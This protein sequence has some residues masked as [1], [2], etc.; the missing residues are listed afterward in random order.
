MAYISF[1]ATLLATLAVA[2]WFAQER[3]LTTL[4]DEITLAVFCNTNATTKE[5]S[6]L[7]SELRTIAGVDSV[8]V[9]S[10]NEVKS[11]FISRFATSVSATLGD[12]PFPATCIV[13]L[14][15]EAR[16][17]D[18]IDTIAAEMRTLHGVNDI[19]YRAA[20]VGLVE[21][22]VREARMVRW[23]AGVVVVLVLGTLLW[24]ALANIRLAESGLQSPAL[25]MLSG[26]IAGF[27][28]ALGLFYLVR[29]SLPT[30]DAVRPISL[31]AG[32]A[33]VCAFG[34][35]LLGIHAV[36][37]V[38]NTPISSHNTTNNSAQ[39]AL[40]VTKSPVPASSTEN[41][42]L[43]IL[44]TTSTAPNNNNNNN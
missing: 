15:E 2:A 8:R 12:N 41:I 36:L 10:A 5:I 31:I 20:F 26:S 25:G 32:S 30:L 6:A 7:E 40:N 23:I 17:K 34:G 29:P 1:V 24:A 18:R 16:T 39:S 44:D 22:R 21:G 3:E 42:S 11:E 19:A 4:S 37:T 35:V 43:N 9:K 27:L 38:K 28:I 13:R 33:I 14:K